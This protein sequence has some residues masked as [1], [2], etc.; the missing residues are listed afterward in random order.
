MATTGH[1]AIVPL[2]IKWA[3]ITVTSYGRPTDLRK[4]LYRRHLGS[5]TLGMFYNF[6]AKVIAGVELKIRL[7]ISGNQLKISHVM[8]NFLLEFKK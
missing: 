2:H 7:K 8:V 4:R 6:M 1:K 5:S 3:A